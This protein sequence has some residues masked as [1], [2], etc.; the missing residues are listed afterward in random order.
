[1]ALLLIYFQ[2]GFH[3]LIQGN[4]LYFQPFAYVLMYG[5]IKREFIKSNN[6]AQFESSRFH[7]Q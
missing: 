2:N 5:R 3:L 4:I 6:S 1:M 7:P